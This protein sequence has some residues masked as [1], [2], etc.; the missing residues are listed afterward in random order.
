MQLDRVLPSFACVRVSC[1][2]NK[3]GASARDSV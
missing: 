3:N 2:G 1:V